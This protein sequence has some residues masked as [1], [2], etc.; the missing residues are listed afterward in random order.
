[1]V[2]SRPEAVVSHLAY[3]ASDEAIDSVFVEGEGLV[4]HRE[5]VRRPWEPIRAGAEAAAESLWPPP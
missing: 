1:M 4:R 5:L 3:S 2:P